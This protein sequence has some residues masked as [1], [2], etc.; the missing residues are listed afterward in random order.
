DVANARLTFSNGCIAQL[1]ASR[2]SRGPSR[3]MQI[4]APEGFVGIDFARRRVTFAQPSEELRRHAIEAGGWP[5]LKDEVYGRYL[6]VQ[7]PDCLGGGQ[8]TKELQHFIRCVQTGARPRVSVEDG[9]AAIALATRVLESIHAHQW[10]G[11]AG[12]ATGP[13]DTPL[14]LGSL[15]MPPGDR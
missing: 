11:H 2:V 9:R 4:W 10:D 5:R 3:R 1:S 6:Q 8:L 14:P 13:L 15:F 12:G 7:E